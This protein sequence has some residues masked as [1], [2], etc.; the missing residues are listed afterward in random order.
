VRAAR[1]VGPAILALMA[2]CS[3]NPGAAIDA[4]APVDASERIP[5]VLALTGGVTE[6]HDA[7]CEVDLA[8]SDG[9]E[10]VPHPFAIMGLV[11]DGGHVGM[12]VEPIA[13]NDWPIGHYGIDNLDSWTFGIHYEGRL[14]DDFSSHYYSDTSSVKGALS[15]DLT[16]SKRLTTDSENITE[17]LCHGTLD[18]TLVDITGAGRPDVTAHMTF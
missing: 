7:D 16:S 3:S 9:N 12:I 5:C 10:K 17:Y 18:A 13:V 2:S 6:H 1:A 14:N 11:I 8:T 4:P 15:F